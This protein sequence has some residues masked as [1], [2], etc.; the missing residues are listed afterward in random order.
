MAVVESFKLT[1]YYAAIGISA[2]SARCGLYVDT[3]APPSNGVFQPTNDRKYIIHTVIEFLAPKKS[4]YTAIVNALKRNEILPDG[5]IDSFI[6][7]INPSNKFYTGLLVT[8]LERIL[9][10]VQEICRILDIVVGADGKITSGAIIKKISTEELS[11]RLERE[12]PNIGLN[13]PGVIVL[14]QKETIIHQ[15]PNISR[16]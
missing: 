10:I 12:K 14:T 2:V 3:V 15:F 4:A 6:P 1:K 5:N 11:A 8:H 16:K 7:P 13:H 9:V